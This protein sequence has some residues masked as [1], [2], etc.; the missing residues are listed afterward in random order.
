MTVKTKNIW[1]FSNADLESWAK[2]HITLCKQYD[3]LYFKAAHMS[4]I[5]DYKGYPNK[6]RVTVSNK[7]K[8]LILH[9]QVTVLPTHVRN[10]C[11][12]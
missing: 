11:Y 8:V 9:A 10:D 12:V 3:K 2:T 7:T 4:V 6:T 1:T 5:P